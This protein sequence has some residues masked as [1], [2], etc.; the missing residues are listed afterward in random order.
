MPGT[1]PTARAF[2]GRAIDAKEAVLS[3]D[4]REKGRISVDD[5]LI[6]A[7]FTLPLEPGSYRIN[8]HFILEDAGLLNAY[9]LTVEKV[10]Q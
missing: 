9:Y 2:E 6:S 4:G 5:A 7:D 8:A 1:D 10:R 3:I